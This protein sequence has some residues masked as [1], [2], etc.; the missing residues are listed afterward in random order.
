MDMSEKNQ[1][2]SAEPAGPVYCD[3]AT[4]AKKV[5]VPKCTTHLVIQFWAQDVRRMLL[6]VSLT[7]DS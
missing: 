6:G 5:E 2:N 1:P 3:I 7:H 4:M